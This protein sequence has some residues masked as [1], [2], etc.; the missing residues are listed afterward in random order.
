MMTETGYRFRLF[1]GF[2]KQVVAAYSERHFDGAHRSDFLKIF[3]LTPEQLF[4]VKQ[5]HGE[6]IVR[7]QADLNPTGATMADGLITDVPGIALGILTADCVPVFFWDS[8]KQVIGLAHAGWRGAV[9]GIAA[10]MVSAFQQ[11]FGSQV[12]NIH[13]GLGPCIRQSAY[14]VGAEFESL[15]PGFY[16]AGPKEG[17]GHLD[18]AGFVRKSLV[19]AGILTHHIEDCGLCTFKEQ[20]HFYSYRRENQTTERMLSVISLRT[21]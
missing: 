9:H 15:F 11:N 19:S 10:K 1:S 16:Q 20:D 17:K 3:G 13:V 21:A 7:V 8:S 6:N 18:L 4:L 2:E 14:E 5:V 12:E